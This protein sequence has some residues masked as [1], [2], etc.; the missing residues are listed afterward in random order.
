MKWDAIEPQPGE[1]HFERADRFVAFGQKNGMFVVGHNLV[2]HSQVP[3]QVFT[4]SAGVPITREVL[5]GRMKT[6]IQ[7]VVGRYR[8]RVRGWDVV[9]EALEEDGTLR[10]SPWRR[11]IGDDYI[12][13]AFEF[14]HEADPDAELYYNDY[15]IE[16]GPKR[17]GVE[18]LVRKLRGAGV[19]ID[20]VGIQE[21]V[22][23]QWPP[24]AE[25]DAA[26]AAFAQLGVKVMITELDV[27]VLPSQTASVNADVG[28]VEPGDATLNPYTAGLPE[29]VQQA[30]AKRYADL[31]TVYFKHRR[32]VKRVTF[33]GVTDGDSWL[34]NFPIRGRTNYPLLFDRAAHPKPAFAAVLR[35][36]GTQ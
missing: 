17:R 21:H 10:N 13:K 6:H 27:D 14:A 24:A 9:N 32:T 7:A 4:D 33:W 8:G 5:L 34:N 11:I 29:P 15:G 26:I 35:A 3:A 19:R 12:I 2:W 28:R 20:G 25:V 1:F 30:L 16:V 23:L 18:D 31:F 22:N 36:A